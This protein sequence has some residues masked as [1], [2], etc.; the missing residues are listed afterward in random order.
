MAV[1][2][3]ECRSPFV[4]AARTR[5]RQDYGTRFRITAS[6]KRPGIVAFV[7]ITT[8]CFQIKYIKRIH[9]ILCVCSTK[10]T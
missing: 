6:N 2:P 9:N 5:M 7:K 3:A 4:R 10:L 8:N 1:G